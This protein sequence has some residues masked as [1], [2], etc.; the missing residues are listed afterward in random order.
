MTTREQNLGN[1]RQER[2]SGK[3]VTL[4]INGK[5]YEVF[6]INEY[7]VGFIIDTPDE[8]TIGE[9]IRSIIHYGDTPVR[10]IGISR[11]VSQVHQTRSQLH[12]QPGWVCGAEFTTQHDPEGWQLL[13][14]YIT[15]NSNNET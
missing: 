2:Y 6:N 5:N 1:R 10:A 4:T 3:K 9:E 12:F 7:G 14:R 15:E 11:H 8:I 13:R